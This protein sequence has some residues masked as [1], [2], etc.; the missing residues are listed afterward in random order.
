MEVGLVPP[1]GVP[2]LL[3]LAATYERR[4]MTRS[5]TRPQEREVG[6]FARAHKGVPGRSEDVSC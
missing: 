2:V 4:C 6:G 1:A 5:S 3:L